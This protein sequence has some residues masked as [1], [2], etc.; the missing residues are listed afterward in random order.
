MTSSRV[1]GTPGLEIVG[2][3]VACAIAGTNPVGI[4]KCA[5]ST[6]RLQVAQLHLGI[7]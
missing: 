4:D 7:F 3:R 6:A 5:F 2:M 1:M